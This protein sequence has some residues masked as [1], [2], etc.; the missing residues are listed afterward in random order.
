M[1]SLDRRKLAD[2]RRKV[3][4]LNGNSPL[5]V[6]LLQPPVWNSVNDGAFFQI[7]TRLLDR[8]QGPIPSPAVRKARLTIRKMKSSRSVVTTVRLA[9]PVR[10]RQPTEQETGEHTIQQSD[11]MLWCSTCGLY[12]RKRQ[13]RQFASICTGEARPSLNALRGGRHPV[14]QY[15]FRQT[16]E[17]TAEAFALP[18]HSYSC[19]MRQYARQ[20]VFGYDAARC[21]CMPGQTVADPRNPLSLA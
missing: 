3:I 19:R 5:A 7:M 18:A 4:W 16:T 2:K 8:V 21:T 20:L 1:D 11:G 13:S 15:S 12:T 6:Q 9:G 17:T 10:T 14:L